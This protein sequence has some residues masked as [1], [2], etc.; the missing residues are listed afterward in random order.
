MF[1]KVKDPQKIYFDRETKITFY[2][3]DIYQTKATGYVRAQIN[4]GA[5]IEVE[6]PK[7]EPK[8]EPKA[9]PKDTGKDQ[10]KTKGGDPKNS[11][12]LDLKLPKDK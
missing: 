2:G 9:E 11:S 4:S 8:A 10:A 12:E 1:I 3:K 7:V 5:F 6:A